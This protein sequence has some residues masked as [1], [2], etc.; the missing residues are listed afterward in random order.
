MKRGLCLK[1]VTTSRTAIRRTAKVASLPLLRYQIIRDIITVTIDANYSI[2]P[3]PSTV[4]QT[5]NVF[6]P[7]RRDALAHRRVSLFSF[8]CSSFFFSFLLPRPRD[9]DF[10]RLLHSLALCGVV[11][12]PTTLKLPFRGLAEN[13]S[14]A[15]HCVSSSTIAFSFTPMLVH[16]R[17]ASL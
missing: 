8:S 3:S 1:K 9:R 14:F 17:A 13:H 5:W 15:H 6:S 7:M 11:R 16:V 10:I 12:L 4:P 2:F